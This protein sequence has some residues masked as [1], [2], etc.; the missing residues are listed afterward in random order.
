M[1]RV[2]LTFE[3]T[4][5]YY[6]IEIGNPDDFRAVLAAEDRGLRPTLAWKLN[7]LSGVIDVE[8][9]ASDVSLGIDAD[10]DGPGLKQ[11]I[12]DIIEGHIALCRDAVAT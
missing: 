5:T 4:L 7:Q 8:Y 10:A 1:S 12:S 6:W 11:Q 2:A 3:P 9:G